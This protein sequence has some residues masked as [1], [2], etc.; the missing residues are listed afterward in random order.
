MAF[1]RRPDSTDRSPAS[2]GMISRVTRNKAVLLLSG[3]AIGGLVVLLQLLSRAP[4]AVPQAPVAAI[5]GPFEADISRLRRFP[6]VTVSYYDVP[7]TDPKAITDYMRQYGPVDSN[8]GFRAQGMTTWR[9][10]WHFPPSTNRLCDTAGVTATFSG[11]VLLPRLTESASLS[12]RGRAAWEKMMAKLIAH[13]EGHLHLTYGQ[14]DTITDAVR[15]S[16]CANAR[17][18]ADAAIAKINA[19][20][21][22]YDRE[23]QHGRVESEIF[24]TL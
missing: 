12:P 10:A 9:V 2:A 4:K 13:E 21:A 22:E 3:A 16:S 20:N 7:G 1:G 6:N 18:A 11:D 15:R 23:T 24:P 14:V 8:D 19:R 5:S 17:A